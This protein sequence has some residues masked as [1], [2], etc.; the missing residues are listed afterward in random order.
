M[1]IWGTGNS[2]FET[3]SGLLVIVENRGAFIHYSV[4][5]QNCSSLLIRLVSLLFISST[6]AEQNL[7]KKN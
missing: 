3:I 5:N 6:I 1:E 2:V 4:K 7:I